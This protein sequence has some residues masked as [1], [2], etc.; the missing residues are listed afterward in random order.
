M[1]K[2]YTNSFLAIWR[3]SFEKQKRRKKIKRYIW[4]NIPFYWWQRYRKIE[5]EIELINNNE[6]R[7]SEVILG[8]LKI[9]EISMNISSVIVSSVTF[10]TSFF[11]YLLLRW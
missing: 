9:K 10:I 6:F 8:K 11:I 2:N 1:Y 4:N 7:V 5:I 3:L